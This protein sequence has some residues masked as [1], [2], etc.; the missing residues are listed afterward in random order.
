MCTPLLFFFFS[1]LN[2]CETLNLCS[3]EHARFQGCFL[4][5]L[6][7]LFI[8]KTWGHENHSQ[9]TNRDSP[10]VTHSK[11]NSWL[12]A[13]WSW[14]SDHNPSILS[15]AQS[16]INYTLLGI[17]WCTSPYV[18]TDHIWFTHLM[19]Y[20]AKWRLDMFCCKQLQFLALRWLGLW[21][22]EWCPSDG[23]HGVINSSMAWVDWPSRWSAMEM[24]V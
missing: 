20:S 23:K 22:T 4:L 5:L 10:H 9:V 18:S 8:F 1:K 19:I 17:S 12:A 15:Q 14:L 24:C 16:T 11:N 6:F 7:S 13:L 2:C 3:L 21:T